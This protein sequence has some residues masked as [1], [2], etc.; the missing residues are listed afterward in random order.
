MRVKLHRVSHDVGYLIISPVVHTFH[1]VQDTSLHG[2]EAVLDVRNGAL[3]YHIRGIIEKPV[4]IHATEMMHC[5]S[6]E[7][8]YGFIVGMTLVLAFRLLL[9]RYFRLLALTTF[10]SCLFVHSAWSL[11]LFLHPERVRSIVCKGSKIL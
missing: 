9:F 10:F 4:L 8:V 5:S 11:A 2:L 1:G 6:V 3:E 7:T